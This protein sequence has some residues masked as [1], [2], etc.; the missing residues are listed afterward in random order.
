MRTGISITITRSVRGRLEAITRDRNACRNTLGGR[1]SS[2]RA[3]T[4]LAPTRSCAGPASEDLRLALAGTVHEGRHR[5]PPARQDAALAH[6]SARSG[7]GRARGGADTLA[8]PPVERAVLG[9]SLKCFES[10]GRPEKAPPD[11]QF[12]AIPQ[13]AASAEGGRLAVRNACHSQDQRFAIA[14]LSSV[15][16]RAEHGL[17]HGFD[18]RIINALGLR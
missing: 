7:G 10:R 12:N 5:R 4:V 9:L 15:D 6:P 1:R 16:E 8:D 2:S 13:T 18:G 3:P 17:D 11:S 14:L